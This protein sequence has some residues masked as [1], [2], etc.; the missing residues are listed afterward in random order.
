MNVYS[1]STFC[2]PL[3]SI[4]HNAHTHIL[5][6][7]VSCTMQCTRIERVQ[8]VH[9]HSNFFLLASTVINQQNLFPYAKGEGTNSDSNNGT[10]NWWNGVE[11]LLQGFN[12]GENY[13]FSAMDANGY[14]NR[15]MPRTQW[16]VFYYLLHASFQSFYS[17]LFS[18]QAQEA[19]QAHIDDDN[20]KKIAFGCA[21][22]YHLNEVMHA[23]SGSL[24]SWINMDQQQKMNKFAED[25]Y[26]FLCVAHKITIMPSS[27]WWLRLWSHLSS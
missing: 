14:I 20:N 15:T 5:H 10:V 12:W 8:T 18:M 21:V 17:I 16:Y 3:P 26:F 7:L 6:F 2:L 9:N 24:F 11:L 19:K 4:T 23:D 25:C 13:P 22:V 1:A 27:L